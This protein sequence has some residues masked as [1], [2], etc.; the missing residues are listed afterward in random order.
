MRFQDP[1]RGEVRDAAAEI[2]GRGEFQQ[3]RSWLERVLDWIGDRLPQGDPPAVGAP[4]GGG[5]S[6]LGQF[7]L[8]LFFAL[9]AVAIA[10]IVYRT[11]RD[12]VRRPEVE[13]VEDPEPEIVEERTA[14][15]WGGVAARAE[16]EGRWKDAVLARYRELVAELVE[17]R[18]VEPVPGR[19][20]GE[21]RVDVAEHAPAVA[22]PFSEATLLFELPWYA[23]VETG[24]HE[25]A[26]FKDAA[27]RV[28]AGSG[29]RS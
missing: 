11:I 21:L 17:R 15:E 22:D 23:D 29:S 8:Y 12:R 6:A 7:L 10:W 20:T 5:S 25:S 28:L 14:S 26:R 19:T 16:A 13:E 2:F 1:T 27:Q 3:R 9:V 4:S 18:I 24:P